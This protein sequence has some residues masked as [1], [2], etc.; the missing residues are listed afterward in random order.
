MSILL[1]LKTARTKSGRV[2]YT[3]KITLVSVVSIVILMAMSL[4]TGYAQDS[5]ADTLTVN[6]GT[7]L[8]TYSQLVFGGN[9]GPT[10]TLSPDMFDEAKAGGVSLLRF[11]G[12]N[13]GDQNNIRPEMIDFFIIQCRA[14]GAE[15]SIHV[16][17]VDGTPEQAAELVRYANITKEYN[18]KYWYI[19]NEP[20]LYDDYTIER[21]N[22]EWRAY[23]EAM[24]AVDPN[25][26]LIGPEVSQYP[27]SDPNDEFHSWV[28]E[29]LKVNGDMVDIVSIHRYPFPRGQNQTTIADMSVNPPEW[30]IIIPHV[31]EVIAETTGRDLP[32]A[33]TE[34]NSHWANVTG[35][36]AGMDSFYNAI[37][38]GD[39]M[40]RLIRQQVE[41]VALFTL[42]SAGDE[43]SW[44]MLAKYE[45]RPIYYVYPMYKMF[46]KELVEATSTDNLVNIYAAK[47]EDGALTLMVINLGEDEAS[48]TLALNDFEP[49]GDAEVWRFDAEHNAEMI[50]AETLADAAEI[51]VPGQSM[52]LYIIP[53]G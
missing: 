23:A 26:I 34:I 49:G 6:A 52:T 46:G 27:P 24:E 21:F 17:V 45:V 25:I 35:G 12:G 30:D 53:P 2:N 43:G 11:P 41:I 47:R 8:G 5:A 33:V 16:R 13:W 50:D 10:F 40:G 29:F 20:N 42:S 15:P 9:I 18:I 44:G 36:E 22:T 7:S 32:V 31:R 1:L 51:T 14:V 48:R 38:W 3:R 39:V 37:W 19:G 28:R 4:L